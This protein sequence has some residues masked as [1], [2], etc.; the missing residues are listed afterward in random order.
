MKPIYTILLTLACFVIVGKSFDTT[1]QESFPEF[2]FSALSDE[3]ESIPSQNAS[4]ANIAIKKPLMRDILVLQN[5]INLLQGLIQRQSNIQQISEN[6]KNVGIP[7]IPPA[8]PQSI[9]EKLPVNILC[10]NFYPDIEKNVSVIDDFEPILPS[11]TMQNQLDALGNID[12]GGMDDGMDSNQYNDVVIDDGYSWADIQCLG[13]NCNALLVSNN[14][15]NIRVRL[16]EGDSLDSKTKVVSISSFKVTVKK[17]GELIDLQPLSVSN[18][19]I[20]NVTPK[21]AP[22]VLDDSQSTDIRSLINNNLR[23][24]TQS[25]Q[26]D[27]NEQSGLL[28]PT[29]LF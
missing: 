9:C 11:V 2:S 25:I 4:Q 29:G 10:L 21:V 19:V 24:T 27:V 23:N 3:A 16:N 5:Q 18:Q 7:F 28:S 15:S 26:P 14:D 8:P 1:A 6:Y 20:A 12:I 17:D 13:N 22:D